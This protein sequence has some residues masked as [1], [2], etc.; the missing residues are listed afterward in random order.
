M[1]VDTHC[2]LNL[3]PLAQYYEE[4]ISRAIDSGVEK[5]VCAGIDI[6][7]SIM[8]LEISEKFSCVYPACGV[9]PH[10]SGNVKSGWEK[11][12]ESLV[13]EEK[14]V[15][16][17]ETG[18]DFYRNYSAPENQLRVFE[19]Q[20]E[21]AKQLGK[22]LIIHN[23]RADEKIKE[24]LTSKN[25]FYGVLHCY[26][27]GLEFAKEMLSLGLH[28][29]FT[30]SITFGRKKTKEVLRFLP[31]EKIMIETDSPFIVPAGLKVEY[32]EPM[33]LPQIAK[34][35]AGIKGI[36]LSIVQEATTTNA[37]RFFHLK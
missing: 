14:V 35:L 13:S 34:K 2:H 9:H 19:F 4:V 11:E 33:Y 26:S 3:P 8:A 12:L 25:Y 16:I 5:F 15:A 1:L 10:D 28:F 17:G 29:S 36:S 32:N 6:K 22:P 27:S 21:L 23:R 7:T 20:I 18:L 24:A 30:G 37:I 31:L